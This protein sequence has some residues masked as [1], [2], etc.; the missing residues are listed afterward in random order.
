MLWKDPQSEKG[1]TYWRTSEP[2][3][4]F[5]VDLLQ[6]DDRNIVI[7]GIDYF[8]RK[9]FGKVVTTKEAAKIYEFL[10][11]TYQIFPYKTLLTDN[12]KEFEN[13]LVKQF[14]ENKKIEQRFTIPYYHKGNGR[15]ERANR[16]IRDAIKKTGGPVRK[17]FSEVLETYNNT[18][19]RGIGMTP[20]EA[21]LKENYERVKRNSFKYEKQ[22]KRSRKKKEVFKV[23]DTVLI[24]NE[25]KILKNGR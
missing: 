18:A 8:T 11:E 20:N 13:K 3:E 14:I 2:G 10:K 25:K 7:L 9:V 16:T 5:A 1:R 19:H 22:F 12:G 6:I 4:I 17:I 21:Y 23:D 15:I 24:K